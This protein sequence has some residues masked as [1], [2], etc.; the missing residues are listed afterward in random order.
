MNAVQKYQKKVA[1][2]GMRYV[3]ALLDA[4]TL[5]I[6]G[7]LKKELGL[8][9]KTSEIITRALILLHRQTFGK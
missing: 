5:R 6:L 4:D 9:R 2:Q 7:E 3:V 1:A 8:Q